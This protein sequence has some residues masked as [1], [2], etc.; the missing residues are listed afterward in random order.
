MYRNLAKMIEIELNNIHKE[1][2]NYKKSYSQIIKS[3]IKEYEEIIKKMK[4]DRKL[5]IENINNHSKVEYSKMIIKNYSISKETSI[6]IKNILR[7][8]ILFLL[9]NKIKKPASESS[10]MIFFLDKHIKLVE[11]KI[12]KVKSIPKYKLLIKKNANVK[13]LFE[14]LLKIKNEFFFDDSHSQIKLLTNRQKIKI[15]KIICSIINKFQY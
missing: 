6:E 2:S 10:K 14:T 3:D 5:E 1:L 8:S 7:G 11:E 4:N 9:S 12:K 15:Q 13:H